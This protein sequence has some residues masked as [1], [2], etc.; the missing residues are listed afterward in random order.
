M[1]VILVYTDLFSESLTD[2]LLAGMFFIFPIV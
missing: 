2:N 1:V